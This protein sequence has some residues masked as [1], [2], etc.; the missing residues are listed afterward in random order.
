MCVPWY[1]LFR[2]L[3]NILNL[4][5]GVGFHTLG[6]PAGVPSG[7]GATP[8]KHVRPKFWTSSCQR[9]CHP[10]T[11]W[12]LGRRSHCKA[13]ICLWLLCFPTSFAMQLN[14]VA[15][16]RGTIV[17]DNPPVFSTRDA[18]DVMPLRLIRTPGEGEDPPAA[19]PA[20]NVCI[21]DPQA[22]RW[23]TLCRAEVRM[24]GCFL[25]NAILA[26]LHCDRHTGRCLRVLPPLP[27]LPS[28]QYTICSTTQ[29]WSE[30][31][32]PVDL[33]PLGG[34][35]SV[36]YVPC[37]ATGETILAIA[38]TAQHLSLPSWYYCQAGPL[39][40][41]P[42]A[43]VALTEHGSSVRGI[44]PS[45]VA[46]ETLA[47]PSQFVPE[48]T[49]H[50]A[51]IGPVR[52]V[53]VIYPGGILLHDVTAQIPHDSD[54]ARVMR[55][56]R[57]E[58]GL[59]EPVFL[60]P[61]STLPALPD[62]QLVAVE[63]EDVDR[64]VIVDLRGI[65]GSISLVTVLPGASSH[66]CLFEADM[67]PREWSIH[68]ALPVLLR[69]GWIRVQDSTTLAQHLPSRQGIRVVTADWAA[70]P[71]ETPPEFE[72]LEEPREAV[73]QAALAGVSPLA[74]ALCLLT[75]RSRFSAHLWASLVLLSQLKVHG[76]PADMW[77]APEQ[78]VI[79]I[80][81]GSTDLASIEAHHRYANLL[82]S[83]PAEALP[84]SPLVLG[85]SRRCGSQICVQVWTPDVTHQFILEAADVAR[86][87]QHRLR[88]TDPQSQRRM[89]ALVTPQMEWPCIQFVAPHKDPE[90]VTILVDLGHRL[91]CL[92]VTRHRLAADL[93]QQLRLKC[94]HEEFRINRGL[95]ASVR[96]GE[97]IRVFSEQAT[98]AEDVG[99][100]SLQPVPPSVSWLGVE[101]QVYVVGPFLDLTRIR[102]APAAPAS[103]LPQL[104]LSA[105]GV[106]GELHLLP[107]LPADC[108]LPAPV[109]CLSPLGTDCHVVLAA[110]TL[111]HWQRIVIQASLF[112]SS[113]GDA[114]DDLASD[115]RPYHNFWRRVRDSLPIIYTVD[116]APPSRLALSLLV[117]D[118]LRAYQFGWSFS[119]QDDP[120]TLHPP[121]INAGLHPRTVG[122]QTNPSFWPASASAI[123][124]NAVPQMPAARACIPL[125]QLP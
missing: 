48:P 78:S 43:Q 12:G 28:E 36:H 120:V 101:D 84:P 67:P 77:L 64:T 41:H 7:L 20:R 85:G 39:I 42:A 93:F 63:L 50:S 110:D 29:H 68:N 95:V 18:V 115:A 40:L 10:G 114:L 51:A 9:G 21:F 47:P 88:L 74:W 24:R 61:Q 121:E 116:A 99:S 33:R 32:I 124:S 65:G 102:P 17:F 3:R 75:S 118:P 56:I 27:N 58:L 73:S 13:I 45:D 44:L 11:A 31:A 66:T 94:G 4:L 34:G 112:T 113:P 25:H 109:Y 80:F 119:Q 87:L 90:F 6:L 1:V 72:D 55:E 104:L 91:Y 46:S 108:R 53:A 89:P 79:T 76:H 81:R 97:L 100:I 83:Q 96:H 123:A 26:A 60:R 70:T 125:P 15:S 98:E 30:I 103:T 37:T 14:A 35:I 69:S 62:T 49:P 106:E 8:A 38:A 59:S 105:Y 86:Q 82:H 71:R 111:G 19:M 2:H 23:P 92:D 5:T 52:T 107:P 16:P 117:V 122:T 54:R 22:T 57:S